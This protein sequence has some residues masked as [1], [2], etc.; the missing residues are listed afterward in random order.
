MSKQTAY[1]LAAKLNVEINDYGS[2]LDI[3]APYGKSFDNET[4]CRAYDVEYLG[5]GE[6]WKDIIFDLKTLTDCGEIATCEFC[7]SNAPGQVVA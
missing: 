3:V 5:R 1:K 2:C 4:H 7:Q 6:L